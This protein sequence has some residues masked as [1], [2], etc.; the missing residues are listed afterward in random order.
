MFWLGIRNLELPCEKFSPEIV[1]YMGAKIAISLPKSVLS[2]EPG[3][4]SHNNFEFMVPLVDMP[5]MLIDNKEI[6]G[7]SNHIIPINQYQEHGVSRVM[8]DVKFI[9]IMIDGS[10]ME[11]TIHSVF[12]KTGLEFKTGCYKMSSALQGMIRMFIDEAKMNVQGSKIFL[13]SL[14]CCI[15]VELI[16][17]IT[18]NMPYFND[19]PLNDNTY[20]VKPLINYIKENYRSVCSLQE[21]SDLAGISQYHLIR[22]FKNSIGKTPY[23]YLLEIKMEKAMELLAK[24]KMPIIDICNECGFNNLSHFNR[25]F[26][27]KTGLTPTEYREIFLIK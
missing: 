17:E 5:F 25:M 13:D 22:I 8:S 27:K 20:R 24:R 21:L 9:N 18:N 12:G 16:R 11:E 2:F 19:K 15:A 4:H 10:Y 23:D 7:H 1:I 26:K 6:F 14:S 3:T